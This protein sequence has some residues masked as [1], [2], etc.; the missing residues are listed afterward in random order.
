MN[1]DKAGCGCGFGAGFG[2]VLA[3]L[4]SWDAT[5][6]LLWTVIHMF[7]GWFYVIYSLL[8]GKAHL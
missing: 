7:F 5:K 6:S 4:I 1:K 3:A 2:M 8:N